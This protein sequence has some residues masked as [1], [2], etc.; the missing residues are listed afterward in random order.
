MLLLFFFLF[1]L[2]FP[3]KHRLTGQFIKAKRGLAWSLGSQYPQLIE[4]GRVPCVAP[5]CSD[6]DALA[7]T[8]PTRLLS[9]RR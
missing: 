2:V 8:L 7:L 6:Y 9:S 3:Q 4:L 5:A 1:F